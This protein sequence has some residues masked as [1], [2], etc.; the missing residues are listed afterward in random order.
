[1]TRATFKAGHFWRGLVNDWSS[2]NERNFCE[3]G[4]VWAGNLGSKDEPLDGHQTSSCAEVLASNPGSL[5]EKKGNTTS[6]RNTSS[7]NRLLGPVAWVKFHLR[8]LVAW[9]AWDLG[10]APVEAP[11][12]L[13]LWVDFLHFSMCFLSFFIFYKGFPLVSQTFTDSFFCIHSCWGVAKSAESQSPKTQRRLQRSEV[14]VLVS[15]KQKTPLKSPSCGAVNSNVFF[16]CNR[17][18][19]VCNISIGL[20]THT[21]VHIYI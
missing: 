19:L 11:E 1:M 14:L 4:Q 5:F 6:T 10:C 15:T 7:K 12:W 20:Y 21:E 8:Y 18:W 13:R 9:R 17:C 3:K 16:W 2:W